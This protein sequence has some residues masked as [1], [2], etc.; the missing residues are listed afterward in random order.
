MDAGGDGN[1]IDLVLR[2][3]S[4]AAIDALSSGW[5]PL[6]DD[7]GEEG[8]SYGP[9]NKALR[10]KFGM[11]PTELEDLDAKLNISMSSLSS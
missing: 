8:L 10:E 1:N 6:D 11:P 3:I 2:N 7:L 5:L 9:C 4:N